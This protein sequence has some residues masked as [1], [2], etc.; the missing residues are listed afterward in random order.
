M[1]CR[2][3]DAVCRVET[4]D[5]LGRLMMDCLISDESHLI[6]D[7]S[8]WSTVGLTSHAVHTVLPR[9]STRREQ[10]THAILSGTRQGLG[11]TDAKLNRNGRAEALHCIRMPIRL[12]RDA[13]HS[14]KGSRSLVC[15]ETTED[16]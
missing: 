2:V 11:S 7:P 5:G 8:S 12:P 3:G 16:P 15:T 14:L 9:R 13:H 4:P 1:G 10:H 6:W